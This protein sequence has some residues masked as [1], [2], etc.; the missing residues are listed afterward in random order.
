MNEPTPT[1]EQQAIL[2]AGRGPMRIDAGA[3]TGKTWTLVAKIASLVERGVPPERILG[4]TFTNKAAGELAGRVRGAVAELVDIGI[5]VDI[6]TYHGF[7]A[8]VL[9]EFGPFVGVERDARVI[10]P[11]FSRQLLI[12][13]I[14]ETP[15]LELLNLT[16]LPAVLDPLASLTQSMSDN[17]VDPGVLLSPDPDDDIERRRAQ[18]ASV[19]VEYRSEKARLGVLDYGDLIARAHE[20][21]STRPEVRDRIADRY[22]VILLDEYQDTDPAQ[23]HLLQQLFGDARTVIAVG[24]PDQTIYEWR[25]ASIENF[26]AFPEHFPTADGSPAPT[27]PLSL[28]RRSGQL[29]LD[30]ANAVRAEVGDAARAPLRAPDGT[31][32][33]SVTVGYHRTAVDEA[34]AIA[35][36]VL[37]HRNEG[38]DYRQMAVLVRSSS[39]ISPVRAA[40]A[41]ADIPVEVASL[42]GL[43]DVPEIV[44]IHAWLRLLHDASDSVAFAR[45]AMGSRGRLGPAELKPLAD[46]V[47]AGRHGVARTLTEALDHLDEL[48]VSPEA[49][50]VLGGLRDRLRRLLPAAQGLSL[51]ELVREVLGEID[52][53]RD[54]ESLP[55][56]AALSGRLNLYRFLDLAEEW[57]PLEGRPSLEAFLEHLALLGEERTEEP[58]AA[59]LSGEDAVTIVTVH[60]AKGLE[61]EV[62]FLPSVVDA[63]F[64]ITG[65]AFD[66]PFSKPASLPHRLRLDSN[67]LPWLDPD[68]KKQREDVLREHALAAEWRLAYVA[69]TRARQFLHVS[70]AHWYGSPQTLKNAKR[71]SPLYEVVARVDGVDDLGTADPGERPDTLVPPTR[72]SA[73]DP[74]FRDGWDGAL[75]SAAERPDWPATLAAELGITAAYDEAVADFQDMLFSLPEP[76][77]SETAEAAPTVSVSG[78]V[79]YARCPKQY[80]WSHVEPLPRRPNPAAARGVAVHR[81]IELHNLG[82][83]PLD[84][85]GEAVYDVT[86][87][88][89]P[90]DGRVGAWEAFQDSRYATERPLLVEAPFETVAHG[91]T[92]RG[93][94]DAIYGDDSAWEIVDFKSGRPTDDPAVGI[95]LDAYAIA[96]ADGAVSRSQPDDLTV[97]FAYLGDGLS[98]RSRKLDAE[99]L[100]SARSRVE[101]VVSGLTAED[102]APRPGD[103]CRR[104]DFVDVCP[105]GRTQ[106]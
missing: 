49:N 70:G 13:S 42:G 6:H 22:E 54:I 91:T 105:E 52:A 47:H 78:L 57:S 80:F 86:E 3:G 17:L 15:D 104:C 95:Q 8:R 50:A 84:D 97:S 72:H 20:L 82:H 40:L 55:P 59:R 101:A 5:E 35:D 44:E 33:G 60:R 106:L 30:V 24:D 94:I 81:K 4:I 62:V 51:S 38:L 2:D 67:A 75:R 102:F 64:P 31:P 77:A 103:R 46:W 28:N 69:V 32:A 61:W 21:V 83:L 73:P 79:T 19:V 100:A 36:L 90:P 9:R 71:P 96:V 63:R 12:E 76:P 34:A 99:E 92:I 48:D 93:R 27:L 16:Y 98:V 56:A 85:A 14:S 43:L 1:P 7:A 23:R 18:L 25:G 41:D 65:R 58:E 45:L 74:L 53:W 37:E 88:V 10:T 66:D 68:D 11:T 29:I 87:P 39:A 89:S 26:E